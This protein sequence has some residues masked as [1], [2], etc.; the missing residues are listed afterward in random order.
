[1][2]HKRSQFFHSY[3]EPYMELQHII[4]SG[5]MSECRK[6]NAYGLSLSYAIYKVQLTEKK[7]KQ[8]S[9]VSGLGLK[10]YKFPLMR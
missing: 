6:T 7:K 4:L 1:M 9:V 10:A 8:N 2:C 5:K 3:M